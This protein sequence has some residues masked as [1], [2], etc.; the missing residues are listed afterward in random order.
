MKVLVVNSGSSS[1]KYRLFDMRT[2]QALISG[3]IDGI[4]LE[5][6]K[7]IIKTPDYSVD[8]KHSFRTHVDAIVYAL[9]SL[10]EFGAVSEL[11]EITAVGHRVVHGGEYYSEAALIDKKVISRIKELSELAPLHNPP[12]LAGIVACKK[13]LPKARQVAVF[14]TAFHQTMKPEKF[15]Y[16]LP[17]ELYSKHRIRRYG[18]HGISH[19]YASLQAAKVLGRKDARIITCHLG[20]G[21]S[22]AAI[23]DGKSVATSMG[24]TPL[25]GLIMG[26][27]SGD[28]DPAILVYLNAHKEFHIRNINEM[29]NKKSGLLALSGSSPDVRD[30]KKKAAAGDER[31][32]LAISMFA[33]RVAFYVSGYASFLGG[34]DAIVFTA[35]IGEGA[36]G[37][38]AKVLSM[39]AHLGVKCDTR[40]NAKGHAIISSHDSKAMALVIP[41]NEELQIARETISRLG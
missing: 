22:V 32:R 10:R 16:A 17:Y 9:K 23:K 24:F 40:A 7:C 20:N 28:I 33:E 15:L 38:R 29:L 41:A 1:L 18:F 37:I 8:R 19:K 27:R 2:E 6:C 30:L 11:S 26:T 3:H 35:G 34:V 25:E 31:A 21:A 36:W 39:L 13:L 12:N 5:R 14:D 4:G